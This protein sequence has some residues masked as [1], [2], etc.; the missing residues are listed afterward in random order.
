VFDE[1]EEP[2]RM[3]KLGPGKGLSGSM[4]RLFAIAAGLSVANIY[5]AQPLLAAIAKTFGIGG[6]AA[7]LIATLT[8]AGYAVGLAF[9]VPLGD[10][11]D[12][13][14]L[15]TILLLVTAAMLA[16]AAAAPTFGV[17]AAASAVL[18]VTAVAGPILVPFAANLARDEQRGA[19]TGAVMSGVL[20]GVLLARTAG[21]VIAGIGGWRA[22][23]AVAAVLTVSL[24]AA[25]WRALPKIEPAQTLG[26]GKLLASAVELARTEPVLRLRSAFGFFGF[27]TFSVFWTS[28]AF[29]L[30]RPPYSFGEATIGLFALVGAAG[31]TA[32]RVTGKLTDRGGDHAATG[33]LLALLLISWGVIAFD[34]GRELLVLIAGVVLLDLAVQGAHVTNLSVIYRLRPEARS[35][36]T[37]VYMTSVFLGGMAGSAASGAA[38]AA[39]GWS[40]VALAGASFAAAALAL[41]VTRTVTERQRTIKAAPACA[42]S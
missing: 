22:V 5:Y 29:L 1:K 30:T 32:A 8:T 25:L 24:A 27:A 20:L 37:T 16:V 9:V 28:I 17:L 18:A 38:L 19:V 13:R 42:K 36:T 34:G 10:V 7:S 4:V 26:Y 31:A 41:W 21:G 2:M 12:R 6:G 11:R 3:Q 15:V 40:G 14:G 23:Y 33:V 35:R 39:G